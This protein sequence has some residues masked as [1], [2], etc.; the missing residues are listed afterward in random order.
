MFAFN[1]AAFSSLLTFVAVKTPAKR[2]SLP[3]LK[4]WGPF[5]GLTVASLL[6]MVDLTRHVLLDAHL[7]VQELHMFNEDGSLTPAGRCGVLA[8]WVGNILLIISLVWYV[9]PAHLASFGD[10]K[11]KPWHGC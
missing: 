5:I 3:P 9:L 4:R 2:R 7:F 6:V 10:A 1:L 11:T 8:T